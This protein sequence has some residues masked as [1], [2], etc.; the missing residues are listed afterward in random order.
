MSAMLTGS[1]VYFLSRLA[2][3]TIRRI[4]LMKEELYCEAV[5]TKSIEAGCRAGMKIIGVLM[6]HATLQ[7]DITVSLADL[8]RDYFERLP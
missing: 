8:P 2:V 3:E 6:I 7:A 1:T 5:R 4:A